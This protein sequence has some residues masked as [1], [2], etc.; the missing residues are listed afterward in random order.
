[1]KVRIALVGLTVLAMVG[2]DASIATAN[3]PATVLA[4]N[5]RHFYRMED[6]VGDP[7]I[8]SATAAQKKNG[9]HFGTTRVSGASGFAMRYFGDAQDGRSEVVQ[10]ETYDSFSVEFWIRTTDSASGTKTEWWEGKGLVDADSPAGGSA[11]FGVSL[12]HG[13]K[14][15][16]GLGTPDHTLISNGS[17]NDGAWHHVVAQ[18]DVTNLRI[19]IDGVSSG[20]RAAIPDE[21]TRSID[22]FTIGA[23]HS[24]PHGTHGTR[25]FAGDL[26]E[27]AIYPTSFPPERVTAHFNA[28]RAVADND[29]DGVPNDSDFCPNEHG[30]AGFGGCPDTDGDGTID[31]ADTCPEVAGNGSNGCPTGDLVV[32]PAGAGRGNIYGPGLA[33]IDIGA[34]GGGSGDCRETYD[35]APRAVDLR[36]EPQAGSRFNSF[37]WSILG[38]PGAFECGA[39]CQAVV[40]PGATSEM[41]AIFHKAPV[42]LAKAVDSSLG[43]G[44]K[45]IDKALSGTVND[46]KKPSNPLISLSGA[47]LGT[48]ARILIGAELVGPDGSSFTAPSLKAFG[49]ALVGPDGSSLVG[50]DGSSLIGT[51]GSSLVGPDGSSLV[52]PDGSS[53]VA[54]AKPNKKPK[55]KLY[56][57]GTAVRNVSGAGKVDATLTLTSA[58]KRFLSR[59]GD[60]NAK[61]KNP[62]DLPV[63]LAEIMVPEDDRGGALAYES[64]K[65][66]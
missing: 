62:V 3:Y 16:V 26:D 36:A 5:P 17:V 46:G 11:D 4:D 48:N 41:R 52:G 59:A 19:F 39:E 22:G 20:S 51:D 7:M 49:S 29:G 18:Y 2:V 53:R 38:Q 45:A 42:P 13:G 50:P 58:G 40:V 24:G 32:I 33:C 61:R 27:V 60:A 12:V 15:A 9:S 66:G 10:N 14:V 54:R 44:A 63:A 30:P 21:V 23:M 35:D 1:M 28:G 47:D 55:L 56:A 25:R 37:E 8:D 6:G 57:L 43:Q 34:Y 64:F 65:I 31:R